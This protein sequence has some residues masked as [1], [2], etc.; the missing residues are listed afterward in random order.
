MRRPRLLVAGLALAAALAAAV[1][2][3]ASHA[4]KHAIAPIPAFS[5]EQLA[6]TPTN[7]WI[8]PHGDIF[9]QQ[10][11]A[12]AQVNKATVKR[13]KIAW[14]TRV[15]LPGQGK[16][17]FNGLSAEGQAV[18]YNGTMYIPTAK[19][20]IF[21]LDAGTG[22]RLWYHKHRWPKG[23]Q[24]VFPANRG[25]SLGD[26][27]VYM[28]QN[29]GS[30]IA[31]DQATGRT[32]W[33]TRLNY[34]AGY[35]FTN[36]PTYVN[37]MVISG[38]SGG[39]WGA[40]AKVMAF[41]AK[42]GKVRWQFNVIPNRPQFGYKSWPTKRAFE[43]GGAVWAT[44]PVDTKLGLVYV[45]VGNPI[46]YNGNVRGHGQELFT[47]SIVAL[48]LRT[49]KYAWHYQFVHHD[50]WDYDTAANPLVLFNLK[51]KGRMRQAVAHAS[52]QGWVYILDRRTGKPILGI[53]ERKVPQSAAQHTWPTQPIPVG[54]PFAKQCLTKQDIAAWRKVPAPGGASYRFGC[55]YTP[56]D[57]TNYT[58]F[59]PAPLGGTDWPPS[60]F[61]PRTGHLY[62]C[63]KDSTTAWKALPQETAGKLKPSATSS[64]SRASSRCPAHPRRRGW[65][66]SSR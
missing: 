5:A 34:K 58:V 56:Y 36:A 39:D 41:D 40:R 19:G 53:K 57:E 44:L 42:T 51:I 33:Q 46:P 18:V 6:A 35:F 22:E 63:S 43:G 55:T 26:G 17:A 9:N 64:R 45:G 38:T 25:V 16:K 12:L 14:H 30:M 13:L 10:Y 49:G 21:A 48:H 2:A 62:I 61:S 60:S 66:R 65:A 1:G 23:L 28:G 7:D 11:S 47:E 50:I 59:G 4:S 24:P 54:Q 31:L 3:S 52:K 37:G 29:D 20:D 27:R 8:A 15:A 32:V